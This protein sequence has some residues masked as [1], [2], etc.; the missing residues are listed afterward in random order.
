[1]NHVHVSESSGSY[2]TVFRFKK[3]PLDSMQIQRSSFES[4]TIRRSRSFALSPPI[5]RRYPAPMGFSRHGGTLKGN[6]QNFSIP[7][8]P[9]ICFSLA[10]RCLLSGPASYAG[11]SVLRPL[12]GADYK[13][14]QPSE[15]IM[16]S[17][18]ADVQDRL[19]L[20]P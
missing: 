15:P 12:T 18:K 13:L 11:H 5:L 6:S 20:C 9:E 19:R 10:D 7:K 3:N 14:G 2:L 1:M 8:G 4:L 16:G 17:F